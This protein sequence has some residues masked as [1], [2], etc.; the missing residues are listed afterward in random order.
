[1][2][3][4]EGTGALVR[5]ILRRD[6]IVLLAWAALVLLY[7]VGT[8]SY[9]A[10]LLSTEQ[11]RANYARAIDATPAL[12]AFGGQIFDP[13]GEAMVIW[14]AAD[15]AYALMGL[16]ALLTVVRHTRAEEESG[17]QELLGAS[18]VG[19]H[20]PLTAAL[21]VTCGALLLT[22][23]LV[24]LGLI[25]VVGLEPVGSLAFGLAIAAAG[26]IFAAVAALAAQVFESA[27]AAI[28]TAAAVLG[29]SYV[30]RFLADGS[31]QFWVKWLTPTG[32]GHL[33]RPFADERWWVL[34]LPL[35]A[36]FT[37]A[38]AS[39]LLLSGR[40]FG[41]GLLPVRP[42]PATGPGLRGPLALAWRLQRGL[43]TGWMVGLGVAGVLLG[44][45]VGAASGSAGVVARSPVLQ[46]LIRRYTDSPEATLAPIAHGPKR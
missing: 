30:L 40:D 34:G 20:A 7:V 37:L 27:R 3:T 31:G 28:G 32:W 21:F 1:M 11:A 29:A 23:M 44:G 9:Y 42:G 5:L 17:R 38:G 25:V 15:T 14:R 13:N 46:E 2:K 6:R 8:A 18:A 24:S 45:L 41:S 33:V 43:L 22:G 35:A 39:Y 10:D 36:T 26:W 12:L 19:R 16:V 4:L